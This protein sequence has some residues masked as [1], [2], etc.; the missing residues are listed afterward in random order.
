WSRRALRSVQVADPE[1]SAVLRHQDALTLGEWRYQHSGQP[2]HR[3]FVGRAVTDHERPP[4][5]GQA[6][7]HLPQGHSEQSRLAFDQVGV[8]DTHSLQIRALAGGTG[9]LAPPVLDRGP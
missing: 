7:D 4:T 5:L 6:L 3:G 8:D 2:K 9:S 1:P